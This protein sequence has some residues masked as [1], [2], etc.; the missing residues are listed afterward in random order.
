M[1]KYEPRA[2]F[3]L[4]ACRLDGMNGMDIDQHPYAIA[5]SARCPVQP[6]IFSGPRDWLGSLLDGE[7]MIAM[8]LSQIP[9][10]LY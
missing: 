1:T 9:P 2:F 4:H 6:P 10:G 3:W 8:D 5:S 7:L